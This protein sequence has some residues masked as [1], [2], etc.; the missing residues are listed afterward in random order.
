[1]NLALPSIID[2][3]YFL[4]DQYCHAWRTNN[5]GTLDVGTTIYDNW[6]VVKHCG[7]SLYRYYMRQSIIEFPFSVGGVIGKNIRNTSVTKLSKAP[8]KHYEN[9]PI[10]IYWKFHHQKLKD[11]K[12]DIFH[13]SAQNIDCGTRLNHLGEAVL[14]S[15]YN[16]CSWAEIRKI[17]YTPVNLS[18]TI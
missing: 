1:M 9:T 10:Q 6:H 7:L 15:T 3:S 17:V 4:I 12:A 18:F 2:V 8:K 14:T 16:L 11:K 13:I 5:Y